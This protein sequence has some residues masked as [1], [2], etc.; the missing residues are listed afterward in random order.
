MRKNLAHL[1]Y[2][3]IL[4]FYNLPSHDVL[5]FLTGQEEIEHMAQQIRSIAKVSKIRLGNRYFFVEHL[6]QL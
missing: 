5:I 1:F 2:V 3:N 6:V 4:F